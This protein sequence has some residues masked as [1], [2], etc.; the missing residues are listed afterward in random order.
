MLNLAILVAVDGEDEILAVWGGVLVRGPLHL[1]AALVE[2]D[3]FPFDPSM[4]K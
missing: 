3:M 1:L 2:S 4:V